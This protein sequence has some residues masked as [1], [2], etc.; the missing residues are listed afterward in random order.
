MQIP[1]SVHL[2]KFKVHDLHIIYLNTSPFGV[3]LVEQNKIKLLTKF[4]ENINKL[5]DSFFKF[6]NSTYLI[7]LGDTAGLS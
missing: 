2:V 5:V 6:L 7:D 4:H 3:G 1:A